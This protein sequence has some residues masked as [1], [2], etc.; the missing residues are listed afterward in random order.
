MY[1]VNRLA[2][3]QMGQELGFD[4]IGATTADPFPELVPRLAAY[5]ARGRTGF[6][7]EDIA[8]RIDPKRWLPEARSLIAVAL[9]YLTPA[10]RRL[11]RRHP[12]KGLHGR[13]TVYAYGEDYHQVLARRLH[14]LHRALEAYLGR[15][16]KARIAV[17]TA[18]LVDR[19]VAERSGIGWIGK[20]CMFYT[21][22]HGSY[23]FLGTL[24]TDVEVEPGSPQP[25]RCGTCDLCLRACP[26]G[27][28]LAPGV[29]DAKRCLSYITQMKGIIPPEFRVAL[30]R[31]VWGCDT[32]QWACPHNAAAAAAVHPEFL[33]QGELAYPDLIAILSWS[34]REFLRRY[35]RTAAA[36]RG[37]ATWKRNALI[38]L[39]N[40]RD[41]RAVPHVVPFLSHPRPELRASAAWALWR[42]GDPAGTAAVRAAYVREEDPAVK[43]EMA[44]AVEE[45]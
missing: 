15:P 6:E 29:I 12:A 16:V 42:I 23:V 44:W 21:D 9:A 24:L 41:P 13:L 45:G 8:E 4:A 11:A 7:W 20:N 14:L 30:G 34:N 5:A 27:A 37:L 17:D 32:C 26:T 22:K 28:L 2:L 19:A 10:G 33:P 25:D 18:P 31:R 43:A 3:W 1:E 35:G 39:G 40:C 36:W 38:A